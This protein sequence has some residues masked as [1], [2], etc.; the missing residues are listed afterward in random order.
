M[1]TGDELLVFP[2]RLLSK[3]CLNFRLY[4][5]ILP[6]FK[7]SGKKSSTLWLWIHL[8]CPE[9]YSSQHFANMFFIKV[10]TYR[11]SA[12]FQI[13]NFVQKFS[14]LWDT[15]V[16]S[17]NE[18]RLTC[19]EIDTSLAFAMNICITTPPFRWTARTFI[20]VC[21]WITN[22][23]LAIYPEFPTTPTIASPSSPII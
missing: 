6:L 7:I 11:E 17:K 21:I 23:R 4:W 18:K 8:F 2:I 14:P 20:I 22:S 9:H 15:L 10:R 5:E 13:Q 1:I 12:Q 16:K 3:I 19:S